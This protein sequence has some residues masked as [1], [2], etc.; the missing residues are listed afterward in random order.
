MLCLNISNIAIIT[1]KNVDYRFI[2]HNITK[3]EAINLLKNSFLEDH[4]YV[5][6]NISYFLVRFFNFFCLV[7]IKWLIL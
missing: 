2:I 3:P 1:I 5:E 6:K 7:Y 4:G